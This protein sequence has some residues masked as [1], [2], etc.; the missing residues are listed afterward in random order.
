MTIRDLR[1]GS[2]AL[3]TS[4]AHCIVG[5]GIAGLLL[6]ARLARHHRKVVVLE[7]GGIEFDEEI[8]DLNGID[9]PEGRYGREKTGRYRGLGGSSSRWGGRI[10]PI[11]RQEHG[12][13][14]H[15]GQEEW[16]FALETLDCYHEELETLFGIGHDSFEDID[17]S[18][19]GPSGLLLPDIENFRARWA[20]C[21]TFARCNIVTVLGK[22]I[23]NN[24]NLT[25]VLHATVVGFDLDRERGRLRSVTAR[26]LSGAS[27]TVAA[28]E[29]TI[30]AGTI[31]TTRLLLALDA[32]NDQ[33]AFAGTNALGRYFQDHLKA[34]VATVDRQRAELT[35]HMLGIRFING[36]RRDLHLELTHSAQ[37][38]DGVSSG[39]VYVS[40]DLARSGLSVFKSFAHGLQERR[41]ERGQ[42]RQA[43][44]QVGLLSTAA[45]WR[46]R[47]RQLYVPR[48]VPFRLMACVEQLPD[49][50]NRISL[51]AKTDRLGMKIA[52]FDWKPRD[53]DERTFRATV[54]RLASYWRGSG[55]DTLCR[56]DWD[57]SVLDPAGRISDRA[58][59]CAHPSGSTRM[60]TNPATSVVGPDLRCHA[61]PNLAVASASVFPTAG[62]AN[63]TFTIMKLSMWLADSYLGR[64]AGVA[65]TALAG[66]AATSGP[67]AISAFGQPVGSVT[68]PVMSRYSSTAG[69][70]GTAVEGEANP[71]VQ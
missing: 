43:L 70:P 19:P 35:N 22:E 13:R 55:F 4:A 45:Y 39:F 21:P 20:K 15:V 53:A 54:K 38:A 68:G 8:H 33:R 48:D 50:Q 60:G 58:V 42:F 17:A 46:L 5:G 16:P 52:R 61:I 10:I 26:G 41:V 9:D 51:S 1:T 28:E 25:V 64:T 56:L 62:S 23:L 34:E 44:G 57:A 71:L 2:A 27:V 63:P 3:P 7:S 24:P 11:S 49:P 59:A 37:V 66:K 67:H 65:V 14:E 18:R 36:T 31:E 47:Y 69:P 29:F 40:M 12:K 32:D 6:A 30:A